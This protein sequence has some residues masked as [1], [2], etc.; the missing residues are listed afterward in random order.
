VIRRIRNP[1]KVAAGNA[2]SRRQRKGENACSVGEWV[3]AVGRYFAQRTDRKE[4]EKMAIRTMA[5]RK[6]VVL[7]HAGVPGSEVFVAG[8]FNDWAPREKRMRRMDGNGHYKIWLFL[9]PGRYEYKF[10]VNDRWCSDTGNPHAVS[11]GMGA[12]NSILEVA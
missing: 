2:D 10:I 11:D 7:E 6:R 3:S 1:E 12:R 8:S 4:E 9:H 5:G